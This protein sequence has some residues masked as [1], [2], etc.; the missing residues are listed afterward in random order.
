MNVVPFRS[1]TC[2]RIREQLDAFLDGEVSAEVASA[3]GAHI[4][5]CAGCAE[6][7]DARE[8]LRA[9]MRRA[10]RAEGAPDSLRD[11][12]VGAIRSDDARLQAAPPAR[13]RTRWLAVAAGLVIAAGGTIAGFELRSAL[14]RRPAPAAAAEVAH[15]NAVAVDD[16]ILRVG[17]GD[18]AHCA[19]QRELPTT[20]R[21]LSDMRQSL[22]SGYAGVLDVVMDAMPAGFHMVE[23]HVCGFQSRRFVHVICRSDATILSIVVT[24]KNGEAFDPAGVFAVLAGSGV[25]IYRATQQGLQI[26]GFET[27]DHL[28]F[29]VSG[30]SAEQNFRVASEMAPN[31]RTV[32]ASSE[33]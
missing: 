24:R 25:Q 22:G 18:H 19:L 6:E 20:P 11:A 32:L 31:L 2:E 3:V 14:E 9:S 27:H 4:A 23:A 12:I 7:T 15:V 26:D 17:L 21:A 8:R 10:V 13:K 30:L 5:G 33:A 29:V 16:Q 1:N 28:A